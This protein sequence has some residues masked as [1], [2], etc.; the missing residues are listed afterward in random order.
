MDTETSVLVVRLVCYKLDSDCW[1]LTDDSL[2]WERNPS[3][4]VKQNYGACI[5]TTPQNKPEVKMRG[6]I[7]PT[8][9]PESVHF[10]DYFLFC[11]NIFFV[12]FELTR[13]RIK[14]K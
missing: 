4:R 12:P 2:K 6:K 3:I 8:V 11:C 14:I 9:P 5:Q 13:Y 7:Q 1:A 10:S